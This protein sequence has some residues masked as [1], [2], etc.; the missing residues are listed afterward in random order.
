MLDYKVTGAQNSI[1]PPERKTP[2][3]HLFN[4]STGSTLN[5]GRQK[6]IL[7]VGIQNIFNTRYLN[8]TSFYRLIELPEA[9]RNIS[10]SL[11]I[12]FHYGI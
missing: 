7:N 3:Y 9:G 5:I 2:G 10:L 11:K 1:V 12:P 4:L 6:L 8:H